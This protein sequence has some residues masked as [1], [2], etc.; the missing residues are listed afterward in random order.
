MR[1]LSSLIE[2]EIRLIADSVSRAH[3]CEAQVS[4]SREFVPTV[5]DP[6][7]TLELGRALREVFGDD[8]IDVGAR[9][10]SGSEDFGQ[11]LR[12]VPG[13]YVNIGNG[14]TASLHNAAYDF[15]D[16]AIPYGV[17]FFTAVAR[18]RLPLTKT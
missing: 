6:Q 18:A 10:Q 12:M 2:R 7:L 8:A 5:N 17:E 9:P 15:N 11:L 13:C 16:E 14:S 1:L 3:G 4:Y